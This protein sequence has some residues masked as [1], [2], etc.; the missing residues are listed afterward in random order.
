MDVS[1]LTL[2][3]A[4]ILIVVLMGVGMLF[5]LVRA[6]IGIH[7]GEPVYVLPDDHESEA[8]VEGADDDEQDHTTIHH[9]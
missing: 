7:R 6:A 8:N 4:G 3:V 2:Q 9:V 1:P 5:W